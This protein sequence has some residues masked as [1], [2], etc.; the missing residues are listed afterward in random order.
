MTINE[1][2][3]IAEAAHPGEHLTTILDFGTEWGFLFEK[4]PKKV[5]LGNVFAVIAKD[6]KK[7]YGLPTTPNNVAKINSGKGVSL[8]IV[9]S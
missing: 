9:L 3:S 2:Y 5:Q 1:A 6:G 7:I 4:D 8:K